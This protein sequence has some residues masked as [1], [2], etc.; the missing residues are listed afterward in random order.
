MID[1]NDVYHATDVSVNSSSNAGSL[2]P[3]SARARAMPPHMENSYA[4]I[5]AFRLL[6]AAEP[7]V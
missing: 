3:N 5:S 4:P 1:T 2:A 6:L 7:E